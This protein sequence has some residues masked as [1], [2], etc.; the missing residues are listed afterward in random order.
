MI[1]K[2]NAL[3]NKSSRIKFNSERLIINQNIHPSTEITNEEYMNYRSQICIISDKIQNHEDTIAHS[4]DSL[5]HL[6]ENYNEN[7]FNDVI[8]YRIIPLIIYN[9]PIEE[10]ICSIF[11]Q[12]LLIFLKKLKQYNNLKLINSF[13]GSDTIEFLCEFLRESIKYHS[14]YYIPQKQAIKILFLILNY[15]ES[16]LFF[17]TEPKLKLIATLI[18]TFKSYRKYLKCSSSQSLYNLN[19][20]DESLQNL[21]KSAVY[22]IDCFSLFLNNFNEKNTENYF[23]SIK[24]IINLLIDTMFSPCIQISNESMAVLLICS[25]KFPEFFFQCIHKPNILQELASLID[26]SLFYDEFT[27]ILALD[28]IVSISYHITYDEVIFLLKKTPLMNN[29]LELLRCNSDIFLLPVSI[30]IINFINKSKSALK[31]IFNTEPK[32]IQNTFQYFSCDLK[33]KDKCIIIYLFASCIVNINDKCSNVYL[34]YFVEVGISN[35]LFGEMVDILDST[36]SSDM[37]LFIIQSIVRLLDFT[38]NA[39]ANEYKIMMDIILQIL[40]P[41]QLEEIAEISQ[42]HRDWTFKLIE[43]VQNYQNESIL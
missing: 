2:K 7:I 27:H 19:G 1:K 20:L 41:E 3:L 6:L 23:T 34:P 8:R 14:D 10:N 29:F 21:F 39:Q 35:S 24:V 42:I 43:M 17:F 22:I 36:Q 11:I 13:I 31:I 28:I 4:I 30:V 5:K 12:F 9:L 16:A 32:I 38:F 18:L 26:P 25:E 33:N 15:H 40:L 37:L